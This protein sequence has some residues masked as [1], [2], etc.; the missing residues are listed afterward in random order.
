[1]DRDG[2]GDG[3]FAMIDCEPSKVRMEF[4]LGEGLEEVWHERIKNV[5]S[6]ST[7][8]SCIKALNETYF[9]CYL[10]LRIWLF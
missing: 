6:E 8:L 10:S 1:M 4:V 9:E 7:F 2:D 5:T 3:Q